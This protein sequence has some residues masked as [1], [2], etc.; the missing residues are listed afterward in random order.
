MRAGPSQ[1]ER[2]IGSIGPGNVVHVIG[3]RKN[4]IYVLVKFGEKT[5]W[6]ASFRGYLQPLNGQSFKQLPVVG[7]KAR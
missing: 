1:H 4:N 2:A 5:G 7:K 3:R 6:I